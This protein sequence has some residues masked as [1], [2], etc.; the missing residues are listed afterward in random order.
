MSKNLKVLAIIPARGG[1]KGLK[2]KN[3]RKILGRPLLY[4]PIKSAIKSGVC[5]DVFVSTDSNEIAKQAIN[6]GAEVP[7]LRKKSYSGD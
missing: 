6:F 3:L 1:S 7:F 2:K 5:D 4:Y